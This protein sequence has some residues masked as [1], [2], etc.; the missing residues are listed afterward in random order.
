M[1]LKSQRKQIKTS[2]ASIFYKDI[3]Q[4]GL[5]EVS[6]GKTVMGHGKQLMMGRVLSMGLGP[7]LYHAILVITTK[8]RPPRLP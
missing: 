1:W 3:S 2:I 4:H 7:A 8:M 6:P 5:G